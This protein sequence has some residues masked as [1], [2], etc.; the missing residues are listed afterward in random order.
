[1][2]EKW[3]L[4]KENILPEVFAATLRAKEL[5]ISGEAGSSSE[6]ARMAG[7]SR[8]AFYK[9][10]DAVFEYENDRQSKIVNF[11]AVLADRPGVLSA[12]LT[13]L[14]GRGAN[15]LT[16]NQNIPTSGKAPISMSIRTDNLTCSVDE[17]TN[18]LQKIDGVKTIAEVAR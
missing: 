13:E 8:S 3:L 9:Y 15:I 10:K 14:Y 2:P 7:I 6:A 4:V 1:M 17:L 16:L 18:I 11:N 12:L 5:L